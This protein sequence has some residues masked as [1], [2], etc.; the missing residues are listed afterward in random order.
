MIYL[1]EHGW[2]V[3]GSGD[4]VFEWINT[5]DDDD[6]DDDDNDDGSNHGDIM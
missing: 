1:A 5:P 2:G 6:E 3:E 4:F